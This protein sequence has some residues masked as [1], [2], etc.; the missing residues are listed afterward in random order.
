MYDEEKLYGR[1]EVNAV[2]WIASDT[3]PLKPIGLYCILPQMYPKIWRE[4]ERCNACQRSKS[5][6]QI[7]KKEKRNQQIKGLLLAVICQ[8]WNETRERYK[9]SSKSEWER[10][11]KQCVIMSQLNKCP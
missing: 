11:Y 10:V 8:C 2:E 5:T 4:R 6:N 9:W 3:N 1:R 7:V